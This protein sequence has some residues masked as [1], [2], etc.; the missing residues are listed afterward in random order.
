MKRSILAATLILSFLSASA[1]QPGERRLRRTGGTVERREAGAPAVILD[2]RAA[3]AD[4]GLAALASEMEQ[5]F[6]VPFE[7]RAAAPGD[8][9]ALGRGALAGKGA[10]GVAVVLS[11]AGGPSLAAYPEERLA[12]VDARALA[13]PDAAVAAERVR[14]ELW[15][16]VCFAAGGVDSEVPHCV[17]K[18]VLRPSDL[19]ALPARM[20]NPQ[21]CDQVARSAA[22]LGLGRIRRATYRRA[23]EEGWAPTPT[24]QFQKAIWEQAKAGK[25]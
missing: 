19:D 17:L 8:P 22:R 20:A 6:Q 23:C 5:A 21:A 9:L 14:R 11:D 18:L 7:V 13:S 2:A 10:A 12:S 16:A 15:R 4:I 24:N 1:A 25:K 3:K